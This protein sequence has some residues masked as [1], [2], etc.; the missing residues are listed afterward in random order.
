M[1]ISSQKP[2]PLVGVLRVWLLALAIS[3]ALAA[4]G[5]RWPQPLPLLQGV[6]W[7][8]VGLP[9]LLMGLWLLTHWSLPHPDKGESSN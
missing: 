2:R 7:L 8:L 6:V 1:P 9:P 5:E 3:A 4:A